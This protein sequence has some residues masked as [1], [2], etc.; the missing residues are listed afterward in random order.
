MSCG[1]S[2][3]PTRG[4]CLGI[5]L[6]AAAIPLSAKGVL[7]NPS[8]LYLTT[9]PTEPLQASLNLTPTSSEPTMVTAS[10]DSFV[11]DS[12]GRPARASTGQ[13]SDALRL[14]RNRF[15]MEQRETLRLTFNL[16]D[17]ARGSFW[18]A[19]VLEVEPVNQDL[20]HGVKRAIVTR[21]MVPVVVTVAESGDPVVE[22]IDAKATIGEAAVDVFVTVAN[23]GNTVVR[24]KLYAAL[25]RAGSPSP[26][27]LSASESGEILL[28]PGGTRRLRLR[29]ARAAGSG[30]V[31]R[32][33]FPCGR[34][35]ASASAGVPAMN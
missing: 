6:I 21:V 4:L 31:V 5:L 35:V 27:E 16:P 17:G 26:I 10:I 2:D 24:S 33:Y 1:N 15:R 23:R 13:P 9:S 19:V 11:M 25:E 32:L 28:L 34:S 18:W 7:V 8:A 20:G 12:G 14:D 29:L 3:R 22:L 30:N